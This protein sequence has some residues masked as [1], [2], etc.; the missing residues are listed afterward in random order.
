[1]PT[2]EDHLRIV[3]QNFQTLGHLSRPN[4]SEYTD[5]CITIIFYMALHFIQAYLAEKKDEHPGVH[6][7]TIDKILESPDIRPLYHKYRHLKDD[8]EDARYQGIK[9][10]VYG[11]R[12]ESLKWYK[13]IQDEI[14][15]LISLP[16]ENEHDLYPLFP[17]S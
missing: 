8:S 12:L 17:L 11:M 9:L 7:Q 13:S 10:T 1:M 6:G 14:S 3:N 16:D 15:K 2:K 4:P 5:W